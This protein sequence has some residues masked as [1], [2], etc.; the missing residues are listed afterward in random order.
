MNIEEKNGNVII[1]DADDFNVE[2][3]FECGQCFHFYKIGEDDYLVVSYEKLL[4]ISQN[5]KNVTFHDTTIEEY[6]E[7]IAQELE[8][9]SL[10]ETP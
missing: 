1:S 10:E 8:K 5:G 4:H 7:I 2:Q 9:N 3:I 6:D